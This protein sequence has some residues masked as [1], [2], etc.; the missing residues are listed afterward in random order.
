MNNKRMFSVRVK[1]F[2]DELLSSFLFRLADANG[3]SI[4]NL[5]NSFSNNKLHFIQ[6][7]DLYLIDFSPTHI[8]DLEKLAKLSNVG[9]EH[10]IRGSFIRVLEKFFEEDYSKH[11]NM[12][13]VIRKYLFYCPKCLNE[14]N[15]YRMSW[16]LDSILVCQKHRTSL[17]NGCSNCTKPITYTNITKIGSCPH[18]GFKL[19]ECKKVEFVN[20]DSHNYMIKS[21]EFLLGNQKVKIENNQ[22]AIK[23][24]FLLNE[25]K[26]EMDR[27]LVSRNLNKHS[28]LQ[29]LLQHARGTIT[30]KKNIHLKIVL[31]ILNETNCDFGKLIKTEVPLNFQLE[32]LGKRKIK[33]ETISCKAPWCQSHGKSNSLI[34]TG[35]SKKIKKDGSTLNYYLYC[36]SCGCEYAIDS[37]SELIDRTHFISAY[38]KLKDT[39]NYTFN[40]VE[41]SSLLELTI[42]RTRR[43]IGFFKSREE[44][45]NFV[46]FGSVS[47]DIT[48]LNDFIQG[49][50]EGESVKSIRNW[51]IWIDY[52]E[53]LIYRYHIKV[54]NTLHSIKKY[55][56]PKYNTETPIKNS[57]YLLL[58]KAVDSLLIEDEDITIKNVCNKLKVS[59]ETIRNWGGN[60][61]INKIKNEQKKFRLN[62]LKNDITNKI[63][64]YLNSTN[65]EKITSSSL[66]G[67]LKIG[68]TVLWRKDKEL[69]RY[70]S[71]KIGTI[72]EIM[73]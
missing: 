4:L 33:K 56:T 60:S 54:I 68:R 71:Y 39:V 59:H 7:S 41:I 61:Y 45:I 25:F 70:I 42:D 5:L 17:L 34:K 58:K 21:W 28:S 64:C 37:N 23:L 19:S 35:T 46:S 66:Y 1:F 26:P 30:K 40:L 48:K 2:E 29:I 55:K 20:I 44:L 27:Q 51:D 6:K 52:N 72:K 18:C 49:L 9:I 13:D 8:L 10:M 3:V 50:N 15:Y 12:T 62:K 36:P 53:F 63:D 22:L 14:K 69:T 38:M 11:R 73:E 32:I 31:N 67:Y 16:K 43:V 47:I 24:L 57:N 65:P